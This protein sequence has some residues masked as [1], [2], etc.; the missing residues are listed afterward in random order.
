MKILKRSD[1]VEILDKLT[2][3]N[4]ALTE[5]DYFGADTFSDVSD[6]IYD[7]AKKLGGKSACRN[8]IIRTA[9]HFK[10]NRKCE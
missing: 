5:S 7:I 4:I 10:F 2:T 8:V 9:T 1:V 3:I 6:D